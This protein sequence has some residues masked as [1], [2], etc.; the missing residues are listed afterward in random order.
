MLQQIFC[1]GCS[2][3]LRFYRDTSDSQYTLRI[4]PLWG[5]LV[6]DSTCPKP[7]VPDLPCVVCSP[8]RFDAED[9]VWAVAKVMGHRDDQRS[10]REATVSRSKCGHADFIL[11]TVPS[12]L[13]FPGRGHPRRRHTAA[14]LTVLRPKHSRT[15]TGLRGVGLFQLEQI[16]ALGIPGA[17]VTFVRDGS[18][19]MPLPLAAPT[20]S[21]RR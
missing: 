10:Y 2:S 17:S 7:I 3:L 13:V 15:P 9:F 18:R 11:V 8:G 4:A 14:P 5:R 6:V 20:T 1:E 21:D 12:A 19:P 16:E